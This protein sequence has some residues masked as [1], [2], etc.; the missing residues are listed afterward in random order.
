MAKEV[1]FKICEVCESQF[2]LVYD[3]NKTN[4][5]PKFCPFCAETITEDDDITEGEKP[6]LTD[7]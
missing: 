2:K 1:E 5:Y 3:P 6:D 7:E 4:G